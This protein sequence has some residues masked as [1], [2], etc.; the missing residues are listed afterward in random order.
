MFRDLREITSTSTHKWMHRQRRGCG[1]PV[2]K[3]LGRVPNM[4]PA[5]ATA[6]QEANT[7]ST[8]KQHTES[9]KQK[10]SFHLRNRTTPHSAPERKRVHQVRVPIPK[11][12]QETTRPGG[13]AASP[14]RRAPRKRPQGSL[15]DG[16]ETSFKRS[17]RARGIQVPR[18]LLEKVCPC[19]I[20]STTHGVAMILM[21]STPDLTGNVITSSHVN[22]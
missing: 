16:G 11:K 5:G 18:R 19:D 20:F 2:S 1:S 3:L 6:V 7:M 22:T 21:A 4:Q 17:P 9:T 15:T 10:P 13:K 12:E 8:A 14:L